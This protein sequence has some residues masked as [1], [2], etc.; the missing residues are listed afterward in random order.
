MHWTCPRSW[1]TSVAFSPNATPSHASSSPEP[2]STPSNRCCGATSRPR[3][4]SH[5][6]I[7]N[8][9]HISSERYRWQI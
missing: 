2:G 3:T 8:D 9:I 6:R 1:P 5:P 4:I 7:W